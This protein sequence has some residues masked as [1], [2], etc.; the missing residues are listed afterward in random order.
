MIWKNYMM[1]SS[2]R[3]S[4]MNELFLE[5]IT[6][7]GVLGL[8]GTGIFM[9]G[10]G[11]Y[12]RAINNGATSTQEFFDVNI[13]E[14]HNKAWSIEFGRSLAIR[15][16]RNAHKYK[17]Y[18][19]RADLRE[20]LEYR[21]SAGIFTSG[22]IPFETLPDIFVYGFESVDDTIYI[23][24]TPHHI[25]TLYTW[26][27]QLYFRGIRVKHLEEAIKLCNQEK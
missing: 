13:L 7:I 25:D 6:T 14:L 17:G 21:T 18:A 8:M 5:I 23:N 26:L 4:N 27:T 3:L 16:S 12:I 2:E 1:Q 9:T 22:E 20:V 24:N 19:T 15:L 10:Y 11:L